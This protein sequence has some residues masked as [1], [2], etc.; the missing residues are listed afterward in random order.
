[1]HAGIGSTAFAANLVGIVVGCGFIFGAGAIFK[2]LNTHPIWSMSLVVAG[3]SSTLL[4]P[5]VEGVQRWLSLGSIHFQPGYI[6]NPFAIFLLFSAKINKRRV[7]QFLGLI[8]T[9]VFYLQPDA[10]LATSWNLVFIGAL[11]KDFRNGYTPVF[12]ILTLMILT[13][14]TWT[15]H[16][17][18]IAVPHVEAIFGLIAVAGPFEIM[19]AIIAGLLLAG[20]LVASSV[21][22]A[23]DIRPFHVAILIYSVLLFIA[24]LVGNYPVPV[25]GAAISPVIGWY[26]ALA[27]SCS[28]R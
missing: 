4:C 23:D 8:L 20:P 10:A 1:M 22:K 24:P 19:L 3:V 2:L 14:K 5:G 9:F 15:Q 13:T 6:L 25:F 21:F 18:L 11:L 26:A 27:A 16:D 12:L 28:R 17:P 7:I